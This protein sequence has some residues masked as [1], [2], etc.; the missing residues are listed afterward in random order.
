MAYIFLDESG[1]LGTDL[2]KSKTSKYFIITF[3]FVKNS[4]KRVL[5]K[6]VKKIY[7][8]FPKRVLRC[9]ANSLHCNKEKPK[10]RIKLLNMLKEKKDTSIMTVYLNKHKVYKIK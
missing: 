3:L 5:E 4:Q 9:H 7:A 10:T 8:G 1:C 6:M 2:S